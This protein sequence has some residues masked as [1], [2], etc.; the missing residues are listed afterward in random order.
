MKRNYYAVWTT[1][2]W[3]CKSPINVAHALDLSAG[4]HDDVLH[5]MS[6]RRASRR[7]ISWRT[8]ELPALTRTLVARYSIKREFRVTDVMREGYVANICPSCGATQGDHFLRDDIIKALKSGTVP[9]TI[10]EMT[11]SGRVLREFGD[12]TEAKLHYNLLED[13][14]EE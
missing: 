5:N 6:W 14:K 7:G 3:M 2:C 8:N 12:I 9:G 11:N 1:P 4:L 13:Q 10:V